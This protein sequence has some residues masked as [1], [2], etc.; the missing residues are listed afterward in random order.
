MVVLSY[1]F[2]AKVECCEL[3]MSNIW[4]FISHTWIQKNSIYFQWLSGLRHYMCAISYKNA[5]EFI[6]WIPVLPFSVLFFNCRALSLYP[7]THL[8]VRHVAFMFFLTLGLNNSIYHLA[9]ERWGEIIAQTTT[10]LDNLI[11]FFFFF[12]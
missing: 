9:S 4:C 12:W 6:V 10:T 8:N 11:F 2:K 3:E 5:H 7:C 1:V